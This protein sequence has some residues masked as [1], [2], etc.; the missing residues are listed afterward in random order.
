MGEVILM[1]IFILNVTVDIKVV[2]PPL[3]IHAVEL[4][5]LLINF[6][7]LLLAFW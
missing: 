3:L 5:L 1:I 4:L 2:L 7:I 6:V